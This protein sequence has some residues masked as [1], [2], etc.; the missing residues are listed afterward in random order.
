[1]RILADEN[2]PGDLVAALR[3]RGHNVAWILV[4]SPGVSD[5][6]ILSRAEDERRTVLTFDRDFG[7]LIFRHRLS[8]PAGVL[9]L[10]LGGLPLSRIIR[11]GV[12][13]LESQPSWD[14]LFGVATENRLRIVHLPQSSMRS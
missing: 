14:G 10:R 12:H 13:A 8:A 4:D 6:Y 7:E 2:C 3:E 5:R 11:I 9:F 1:M